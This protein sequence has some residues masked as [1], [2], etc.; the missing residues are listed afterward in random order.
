MK[1]EVIIKFSV[2][3]HRNIRSNMESQNLL[4]INN[5]HKVFQVKTTEGQKDLHALSGVN[6]S[7]QKGEVVSVIGESGCGKTTLGKI[8]LNLLPLSSGEILFEGKN[9]FDKNKADLLAFRKNAQMVFQNPFASLNPRRTIESTLLQPLKIHEKNLSRK[10]ALKRIDRLLDDVGISQKHKTRYP[11]QFSGGQRQRINIARALASRPKLIVCD[12]AVSALDVSVQAQILN[13]LLDLKDTY[14]LSY[15]FIAHDLATVEFISDKICV[16][17]L[18]QVMELT[19]KKILVKNNLHPYT[20]M[21]FDSHP[22]PD[23]TKKHTS[24]YINQTIGDIP[25]PLNKPKGC[26]FSSRCIL[27]TE[28]C[29]QPQTLRNLGTATLPHLVSCHL[30]K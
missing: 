5:L 17:Y 30:A 20:K 16:M 27:A 19:D 26:P 8:V 1:V 12:E 9:I 2:I 23:P 6:L 15:L 3:L 4:Q 29:K 10:E 11:H 13:L 14:H 22:I 24:K 25:S 18:G 21:L 7:I 28:Q